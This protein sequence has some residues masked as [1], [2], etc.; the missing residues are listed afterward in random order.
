MTD[1]ISQALVTEFTDMVHIQAEQSKSRLRGLI[2]EKPVRG[3]NASIERLDTDGIANEVTARHAN[4]VLSEVDHTR[5]E[6][7]MRDFEYTI[8]LDKFDDLQVLIDPSSE[9]AGAVARKMMRT[10]DYLAINAALGAVNTG[11]QFGTSVT[12]ANDGGTTIAHG[13]TGLTYDKLLTVKENFINNEVGVDDDEEILLLVTGKQHSNMMK[14]VELT[15]GD[16]RREAVVEN[17]RIVSALGMR[18]ITFGTSAKTN[19]LGISGST[20]SCIAMST[21]GVVVGVN[22]DITIDVDRRPD[23]NNMQQV[24]ARFFL[25]ATRREGK[26]IQEIQCTEV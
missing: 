20:R 26:L 6:I 22:Q 15:S 8:G 18:V 3:N 24:Q 21:R 16:F 17:G 13:S 23:K 25:G 5:R 1:S 11:K 9:Y 2:G 12:Y 19:F 10:Y 7:K 4:T 14:E